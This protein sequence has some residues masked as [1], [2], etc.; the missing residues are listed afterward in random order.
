MKNALIKAFENHQF[1]FVSQAIMDT[2]VNAPLF[3][4][5]LL[6]KK[7]G[8][9]IVPPSTFIDQMELELNREC[10]DSLSSFELNDCL[11]ALM[12]EFS[13]SLRSSNMSGVS[14][15]F[16]CTQICNEN[17]CTLLIDKFS[18]TL[19]SGFTV[20][21]EIVERGTDVDLGIFRTSLT[22]LSDAG[23]LLALDDLEDPNLPLLHY[24]VFE[25]NF[26]KI[27][28]IH[29]NSVIRSALS[30]QGIVNEKSYL[31]DK[32]L[33]TKIIIERIENKQEAVYFMDKNIHLQQGYYY[34]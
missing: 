14:F 21:V 24:G 5:A 23:F 27:D 4:E 11:V 10:L 18:E 19:N 3:Y 28:K 25:Y 6:R 1:F 20:V 33:K 17:F 32:T 16:T 8:N 2:S 30:Y 22:R 7:E 26:I 34:N 15:N 12:Y 31:V 29:F 13:E 9:S